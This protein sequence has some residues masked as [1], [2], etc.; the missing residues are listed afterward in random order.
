[1]REYSQGEQARQIL[2]IIYKR[3][4][5]LILMILLTLGLCVCFTNDSFLL[6]V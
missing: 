5:F 6:I 3:G 2:L 4:F 1:M